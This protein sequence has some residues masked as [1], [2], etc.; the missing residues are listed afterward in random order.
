[1]KPTRQLARTPI[2]G[3]PPD[4]Q[5]QISEASV[6]TTEK[7]I[8]QEQLEPPEGNYEFLEQY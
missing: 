7:E 1:M 3:S 6:S 8:E 2:K 4:E 5:F